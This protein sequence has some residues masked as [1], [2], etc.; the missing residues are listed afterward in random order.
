MLTGLGLIALLSFDASGARAEKD[1]AVA[2]EPV[3]SPVESPEYAR[4][5]DAAVAEFQAGRWAE[6]RALFQRAHGISPN[7]RTL[8]GIGMAAF[9]MADYPGAVDALEAALDSEVR[10]LT[11]E[12]RVQVGELLGRAR[13]LVGRLV[14]PVAAEGMRLSIDGVA[15]DVPGGWPESEGVILLGVGAHEVVL[16]DRDGHTARTRVVVRGGEDATLEIAS[17]GAPASARNGG[18][19][20]PAPWIVAGIGA[21]LAIAG[22]V[23]YGVG[24]AE[25]AR[26]DGASRGTPWSSV[27]GVYDSAP[28]MTGLGLGALIAGLG[29]AVVGTGWGIASLASSPSDARATLY[30]RPTG[31]GVE[32]SF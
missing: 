16:R 22:G 20:D 6:A 11:A 17:P 30:L 2:P 18:D 25:I 14:V 4:T 27:A 28:V 19:A 8:R 3:E 32:G 12:Q 15:V 7:A 29:A 21:G 10:P 1:V 31:L 9:E 26:V 24:A 23:L 13:A 5:I